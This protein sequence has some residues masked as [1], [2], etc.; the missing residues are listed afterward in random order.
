MIPAE[1]MQYILFDG[2]KLTLLKIRERMES[3]WQVLP[4]LGKEKKSGE[5]SLDS[6]AKRTHY[7]KY[8]QQ[9]QIQICKFIV[10]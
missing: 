1:G 6:K 2:K 9:V 4:D 8:D 7:K 3:R 10:L 5:R